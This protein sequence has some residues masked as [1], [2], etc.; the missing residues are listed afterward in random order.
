[1]AA[2]SRNSDGAA[3]RSLKRLA[4]SAKTDGRMRRRSRASESRD[5]RLL[6]EGRRTFPAPPGNASRPGKASPGRAPFPGTKQNRRR[7]VGATPVPRDGS[8]EW[9]SVLPRCPPGCRGRIPLCRRDS[10]RPQNALD[11]IPS[12]LGT[13]FRPSPL[14]PH[15]GLSRLLRGAWRVRGRLP[16]ASDPAPGPSPGVSRRI[17]RGSN[18][19]PASP[20]RRPVGPG[21]AGRRF[22]GFAG[23]SS[24]KWQG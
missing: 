10:T 3:A 18:P 4:P 14:P 5:G 2:V 16:P 6:P 7:L 19:D 8:R 17:S 9:L 1:M 22:P 12:L 21:R 23:N 24:G 11:L 13:V 20:P 15:V